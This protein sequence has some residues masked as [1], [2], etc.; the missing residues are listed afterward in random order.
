M[1]TDPIIIALTSLIIGLVIGILIGRT[2]S[3]ATKQRQTLTEELRKKDNELKTYQH[4]VT[5]HF[6]TTSEL[7]N[8]LTHSYKEV[9]QH[10]ADSAMTLTNPEISNKLLEAGSGN[11]GTAHTTSNTTIDSSKPPKD[12]TPDIN[13]ILDE[14]YGLEKDKTLATPKSAEDA[15]GNEE[16]P[17]TKVV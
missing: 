15:D 4:K 5:E 17:T 11:L 12:Y 14:S 16:D 10:L 7:V 2:F 1:P 13:G 6:I 9:H 8:N 3:N